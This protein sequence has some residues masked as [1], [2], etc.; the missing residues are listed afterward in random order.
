MARVG[1]ARST[2]RGLGTVRTPA[3]AV[4]PALHVDDAIGRQKVM[5]AG[6]RTEIDKDGWRH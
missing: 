1:F 3:D 4:L 6:F 2:S 5:P